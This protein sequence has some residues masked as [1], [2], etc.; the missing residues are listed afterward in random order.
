MSL[1]VNW[2]ICERV[3]A[4]LIEKVHV[5]VSPYCLNKL[6]VCLSRQAGEPRADLE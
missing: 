4:L 2:Y 3:L 1:L 6:F 5:H